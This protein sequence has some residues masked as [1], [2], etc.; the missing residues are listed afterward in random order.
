MINTQCQCCLF[1]VFSPVYDKSLMILFLICPPSILFNFQEVVVFFSVL[2][3]SPI[4]DAGEA[5]CSRLVPSQP[6][7]REVASVAAL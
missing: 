4:S 2:T 1:C 6:Q 7:Q 3:T 5:L